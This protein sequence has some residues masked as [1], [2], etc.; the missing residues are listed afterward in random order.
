MERSSRFNST[1]RENVCATPSLGSAGKPRLLFPR[2][3][4]AAATAGSL[5]SLAYDETIEI[6][7]RPESPISKNHEIVIITPVK[8]NQIDI[9]DVKCNGCLKNYNTIFRDM[10]AYGLILQLI[11]SMLIIYVFYSNA[12]LIVSFCRSQSQACGQSKSG[13][14]S[15]FSSSSSVPPSCRCVLEKCH[16]NFVKAFL[17]VVNLATLGLVT[18][19]AKQSRSGSF[20]LSSWF[21]MVLT[22]SGGWLVLIFCLLLF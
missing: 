10:Q 11:M 20:R 8:A 9:Y 7:K 18:Y 12:S 2:P 4:S 1:M 5:R 14:S 3:N 19:D 13:Y 21:L 15:Y 22:W 6:R 17:A 16:Q